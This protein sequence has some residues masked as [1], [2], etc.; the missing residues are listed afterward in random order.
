MKSLVTEFRTKMADLSSQRA[1][2]IKQLKGSTE[3]DL[4]DSL[5]NHDAKG[6]A[7]RSHPFWVP[8]TKCSAQRSFSHNCDLTSRFRNQSFTQK[9]CRL[10]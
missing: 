6:T 7:A 3:E 9:V 8:S 4:H 2:L 1:D 10:V 5:K